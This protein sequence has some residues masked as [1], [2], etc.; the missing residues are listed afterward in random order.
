MKLFKF[1][2]GG[3]SRD[4]NKDWLVVAVQGYLTNKD[5]FPYAIIITLFDS[6]WKKLPNRDNL[7]ISGVNNHGYI[8]GRFYSEP[9]SRLLLF[10]YKFSIVMC[11]NYSH[12]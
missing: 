12:H 6:S 10:Y 8:Y 4:P 1:E 2:V 7:T 5:G 9:T 3:W 11:G